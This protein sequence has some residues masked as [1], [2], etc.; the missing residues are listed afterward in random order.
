MCLKGGVW[1]AAVVPTLP[2]NSVNPH[3]VV[4]DCISIHTIRFW[5]K[6]MYTYGWIEGG[7]GQVYAYVKICFLWSHSLLNETE[8]KLLLY[9][10]S[11]L[12]TS[13]NAVGWQ[14]YAGTCV[15][16]NIHVSL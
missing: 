1:G 8:M 14:D 12:T 16:S 15:R 13:V 7:G 6:C 5:S 10:H 3:F 4:S 2:H 9:N 11:P